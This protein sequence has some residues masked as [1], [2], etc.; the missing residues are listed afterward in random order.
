MIESEILTRIM[1]ESECE[2]KP[3]YDVPDG[4]FQGV[5]LPWH[6]AKETEAEFIDKAVA[7]LHSTVQGRKSVEYVP[8]FVRFLDEG[9]G[10]EGVVKV[11]GVKMR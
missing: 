9:P 8:P 4:T 11:Y 2:F 7:K 6:V 1:K 3:C 10:D 5:I